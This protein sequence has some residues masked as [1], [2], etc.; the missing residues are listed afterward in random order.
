MKV[1]YKPPRRLKDGTIIYNEPSTRTICW[2]CGCEYTPS[3]KKIIR[4]TIITDKVFKEPYT[5]CPV[6]GAANPAYRHDTKKSFW[7]KL[8]ELFKK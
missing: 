6:C 1:Y 7:K 2:S 3:E 4:D 5:H 8:K